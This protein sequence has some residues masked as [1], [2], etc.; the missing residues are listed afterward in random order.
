MAAALAAS[1]REIIETSEPHQVSANEKSD[2]AV[3]LTLDPCARPLGEATLHHIKRG[4]TKALP[5]PLKGNVF[6]GMLSA[7]GGFVA[8]RG[9]EILW[10]LDPQTLEYRSVHTLEP[11]VSGLRFD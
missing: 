2:Y 11:I 7:E 8:L 5:D 9:S 1:I 4:E 10:V 3:V 6:E